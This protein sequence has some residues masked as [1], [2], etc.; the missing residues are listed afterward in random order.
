MPL[1]P[2]FVPPCLPIKAPQPPTGGAWLHD[3]KQDGFR[4][5]A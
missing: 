2:G 3:I 4:L 5:V 1:P